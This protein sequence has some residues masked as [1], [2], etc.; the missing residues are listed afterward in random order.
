MIS[1]FQNKIDND[2]LLL[3]PPCNF[4]GDIVVIDSLQGLDAACEDLLS[5]QII[6]F[7]TETRPAFK[8]GVVNR[9]ALL[10]LS[11]EMRCY[12]FR[13]CSVQLEKEIA[14][15]LEHK[16]IIKVGVA[17]HDDIKTL[18]K[19][20]RF[21]PNGFIDLQSIVGQYGIGELS[22]RKMAAV[23]IGGRVSKAQRLSNWEAV[24]LTPAQ[25]AY[26]ATDAWASLMIYKALITED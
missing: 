4:E 15:V 7:D 24:E 18:N 26:A 2:E 11:T 6:G 16:D 20:R 25:Q 8:A 1:R 22:L 17:I 13:L 12:L 10:Q 19:L 3:L 5:Q 9:V 14:N 23:T 21:R